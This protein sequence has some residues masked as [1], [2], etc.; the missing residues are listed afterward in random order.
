MSSSRLYIMQDFTY[1]I[2]CKYLHKTALK[3]SSAVKELR[4][5]Y[6]EERG[7][8]VHEDA[9]SESDHVA[10]NR[11]WVKFNRWLVPGMLTM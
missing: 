9:F 10:I 7:F 5:R 8:A 4:N 2:L 11:F 1:A 3:T 6:M